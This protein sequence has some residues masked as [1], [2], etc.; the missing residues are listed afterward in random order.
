[1]S[2]KKKSNSNWF[3]RKELSRRELYDLSGGG[4]RKAEQ[5]HAPSGLGFQHHSKERKSKSSR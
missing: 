1:M 2:K 4:F 3:N 5:L